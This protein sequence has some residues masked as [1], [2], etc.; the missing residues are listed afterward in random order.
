VLQQA[1]APLQNFGV[2]Y[3]VKKLTCTASTRSRAG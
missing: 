3:E 1:T 2:T